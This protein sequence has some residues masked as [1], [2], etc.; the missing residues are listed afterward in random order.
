MKQNGAVVGPALGFV[1]VPDCNHIL[2]IFQNDTATQE[3]LVHKKIPETVHQQ[4]PKVYVI[5]FHSSVLVVEIKMEVSRKIIIG[6][7][8]EILMMK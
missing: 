5:T 4:S 6:L 2:F 7:E 3:N 8:D 1:K